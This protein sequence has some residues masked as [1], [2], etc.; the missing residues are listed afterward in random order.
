MIHRHGKLLA[1]ALLALAVSTCLHATETSLPDIIEEIRP[2]I[3]GI[4]TYDALRRPPALLTGT[5][6][7]VGDGN[8]A[9]TNRHVLPEELAQQSKEALVVFVG[10]G[11]EVQYRPARMV[12]DDEQHDLALLRFDGEPLRAL[13]LATSLT[14]R[15]GTDIAFTGF[16]I[17]AVLGLYPVTHRG[18]VSAITPIVIPAG[19]SRQLTAAKI[20]TLRD[21]FDVLQ[22]DATAY[23]GNSGSPVYLQDSGRVVGVINQVFVKGRK[24][25][26]LRDPSAITYAIPVVHLA[27]LLERAR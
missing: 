2:S 1:L 16:P 10:R 13:P 7:I 17:G 14:V 25:D 26:I 21:P 4:G 22:L 18:I 6:F 19:D 12:A 8:L 5:G 24:E 11:R 27:T 15:E 23:P 3:V 9:A 20:A